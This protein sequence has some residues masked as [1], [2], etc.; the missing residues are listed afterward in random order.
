MPKYALLMNVILVVG[1]WSCNNLGSV[2]KQATVQH[3]K[4]EENNDIGQ[5]Q[6]TT[7]WSD[8]DF[9]NIDLNSQRN[10]LENHLVDF[11]IFLDA[12]PSDDVTPAVY[13]TLDKAKDD[14]QV[15]GFFKEKF[16]TLLYDPNSILRNDF[17][18]SKVLHYLISSDQVIEA[19]KIKYR[20]LLALVRQN[21]PG[22]VAN[23]FNFKK[24]NGEQG[25]LHEVKGAYKLVV[26]YDP[27]CSVCNAV[28]TDLKTVDN[29]VQR[30]K[31]SK[32]TFLTVCAVGNENEWFNYQK[33][34]PEDWI[35]GY[36]EEEEIIRNGLYD[37]KAFPTFYL[38]GEDNRVLLKDVDMERLVGYI[39][40]LT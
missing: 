23:N 15:F 12:I 8:F 6:A 13:N 10:Q 26:F 38:I 27:L 18:Y 24:P 22:A 14:K 36:N 5:P 19:E 9:K 16:Y 34:L 20:T 35:N 17:Y 30:T 3:D 40:D 33:G 28:M 2:E 11:V 31:E 25:N 39:N 37:L 1:L 4:V 21:L 32:V 7:F 29:L